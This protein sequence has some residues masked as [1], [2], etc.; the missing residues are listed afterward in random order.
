MAAGHY[1]GVQT[2]GGAR[3]LVYINKTVTI[4]GGYT[5]PDFADP[6]NPE[7]NPTILDAESQGRV[8]Y[9]K[10][11]I[12]STIE[13]LWITGGNATHAI[14]SPWEG[15]GIY[16]YDAT[17]VIANNVISHNVA[18]TGTS[19]WGYGGGMYIR[20]SAVISGN[21]VISNVASTSYS[22]GGGG[23]YIS[24]ADGVQIINNVV[25]SNTGSITGGQGYGGSIYLTHSNGAIVDG[26]RIEHNDPVT[27]QDPLLDANYL[28]SAG[29]L[30][31]DAGV[32]AGVSTDIDGDPR[33]LGDGYDI[34]ADEFAWRHIYLP[35]VVRNY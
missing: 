16:G 12:S 17:L 8:I 26:N 30:A 6:P 14:Q 22:G 11:Y 23:M 33:P 24:H 35:L 34:G 21:R 27:G 13:G 15:G 18:S 31:I 5:A 9:G 1:T 3:Q 4:R 2:I 10:Q 20:G 28:L 32:D 7:D 29:S 19:S 25:L